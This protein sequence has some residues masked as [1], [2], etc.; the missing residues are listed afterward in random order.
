MA[1]ISGYEISE[2]F[3]VSSGG[4]KTENEIQYVIDVLKTEK[5]FTNVSKQYKIC[6]WIL[7]NSIYHEINDLTK[8]IRTKWSDLSRAK[9]FDLYSEEHTEIVNIMYELSLHGTGVRPPSKCEP[10]LKNFKKYV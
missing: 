3:V 10:K 6:L 7:Y 2:K 4:F 9:C 1:M 8:E 5:I